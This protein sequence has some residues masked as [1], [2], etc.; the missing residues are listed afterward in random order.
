[1]VWIEPDDY[2]YVLEALA[3]ASGQG[4]IE[5][6]IVGDKVIACG[7]LSQLKKVWSITKDQWEVSC[8]HCEGETLVKKVEGG[9]RRILNLVENMARKQCSVNQSEV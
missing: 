7:S 6:L 2:D 5:K 8:S 9:W 3:E 4:S 1:M